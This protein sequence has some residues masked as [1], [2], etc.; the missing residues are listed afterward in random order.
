MDNQTSLRIQ[1]TQRVDQVQWGSSCPRRKP[2][3]PI[4]VSS[5]SLRLQQE[6]DGTEDGGQTGTGASGGVHGTGVVGGLGGDGGAGGTGAG[7]Q[8]GG[9]GSHHGG[10]D[11]GGR[12]RG[13]GGAVDN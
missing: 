11:G 7:D 12:H 10:G 9:G 13:G 3:D 6:G 2:T 4:R 5:V 1:S 8:G